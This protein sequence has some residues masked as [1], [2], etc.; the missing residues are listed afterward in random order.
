M[1]GENKFLIGIGVV[2]LLVVA[3][4]IFFFSSKQ[5]V[6]KV[7]NSPFDK[8]QLIDGAKHFKGDPG[9]PV[10]I[11]EFGDLQC[12]A[13]Q[14][15]QPIVRKIEEKYSQNIYFVFR[16]Y[17]LTIHKNSEIAAKASEAAGDQGK[18]FE[19]VD[20]MYTNQNEWA[21][22]VNPRENFQK[23]AT[24]LGLN[25]DQFN[26]NMQKNWDNIKTDYALG[27]RAGVQ[28]TPTF[29]INGEKYPGVVD[30]GQ[31]QQI[32]EGIV[33]NQEPVKQTP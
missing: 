10:T 24:Q 32:I 15:A 25:L 8:A 11:V 18:F 31:F 33:Q 12:P 17:P 28:S 4:G 29:F 16:H 13:C 1:S 26:Q 2:T 22:D 14:A 27:N 3:V 30:E 19:M 23:Y 7:D 21:Q 6:Q 20:L 5:S 9:A